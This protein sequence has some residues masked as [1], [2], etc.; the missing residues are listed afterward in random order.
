MTKLA[1]KLPDG[2]SDGLYPVGRR[3]IEDPRTARAVVGTVVCQKIT[4]DHDT[5]AVV[6]TARFSQIEAIL[7]EAD[8]AIVER[9]IERASRRRSG[10]EPLPFELEQQ[11]GAGDLRTGELPMP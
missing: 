11:F 7:D 9:L 3:L 10:R 6:V 8:A 5:G 4:T 2:D 1:S